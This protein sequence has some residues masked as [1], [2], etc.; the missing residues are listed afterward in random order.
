M[1]L[2]YHLCMKITA[3]LSV[4][5]NILSFDLEI[6][7]LKYLS[8]MLILYKETWKK[9]S[10]ADG[11]F[12]QFIL[13]F[14]VLISWVTMMVFSACCALCELSSTCSARTPQMSQLNNCLR[15]LVPCDVAIGKWCFGSGGLAY[16]TG[17]R[18][19]GVCGGLTAGG[20]LVC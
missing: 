5:I 19:Q 16:F 11:D 2:V 6:C 13:K 7:C 12:R 3:L 4:G 20:L 9:Y 17:D 1:P 18:T 14:L 8:K 15:T 10:L